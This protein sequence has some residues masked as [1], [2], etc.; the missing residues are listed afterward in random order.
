MKV[1]LQNGTAKVLQDSGELVESNDAVSTCTATW[2]VYPFSNAYAQAP[3]V[4]SSCHPVWTSLYC[5]E[6]AIKK[7]G[8]G[9]I[10]TAEYEGS[11]FTWDSDEDT[12]NN[13][14]E[15]SCT[16]R[17]EAIETHPDFESWAGTPSVPKSGIFDDEGM[18]TGW[19]STTEGG[20]A[21]AGVRSY[22]VPSYSANI[23]SVS[24]SKPSLDS[25]GKISSGG[26][27]PS[28]GGDREWLCTGISYSSLG[29]AT[30]SVVKTYL[31]SAEGG[32]NKYIYKQ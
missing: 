22:L 20:R 14:V 18:F 32:W 21:M 24:S 30:Y 4:G 13:T 11:S 3:T 5:T 23:S 28:L 12:D 1:R 19:T 16:M 15:V 26:S 31:S 2:F 7:Y 8:T 9:A 6:F 17:E 29:D 10:I 27:L 25:I